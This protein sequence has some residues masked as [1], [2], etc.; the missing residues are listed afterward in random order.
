MGTNPETFNQFSGTHALFVQYDDIIRSPML[1]VM[2]MNKRNPKLATLVDLSSICYM[3]HYGIYEWYVNRLD[4][5]PLRA[6]CP[7]LDE[8]TAFNVMKTF[9][10]S[11][12]IYTESSVQLPFV[13][14]MR[15]ILQQ[16]YNM[17]VFIYNE[18]DNPFVKNDIDELFPNYRIEIITGSVREAIKKVPNDATYV[19]SNMLFVDVL[20]ELDK[21]KLSNIMVAGNYRYN[22]Q[23]T[24]HRVMKIH[25]AKLREKCA[26]K[27]K[28]FTASELSSYE[29]EELGKFLSTE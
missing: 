4:W 17:K 12:K 6:L 8:E 3:Y 26:F 21:L 10:A 29:K 25:L 11:D 28:L 20:D 23:L 1:N 14:I 13:E 16:K 24:D 15:F 9:I 7:D 22:Y 19:F 18:F 2:R 27:L 5:N